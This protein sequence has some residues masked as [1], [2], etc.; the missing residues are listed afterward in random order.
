ML[1]LV[2]S[3]YITLSAEI[4]A[5]E[6]IKVSIQPCILNKNQKKLIVDGVMQNTAP[7]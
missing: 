2:S 3:V 1:F 7:T 5:L 4:K 6:L